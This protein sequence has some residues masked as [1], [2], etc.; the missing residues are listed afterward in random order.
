MLT[1]WA[2]SRTTCSWRAKRRAR[3]D[4]R[5][6]MELAGSLTMSLSSV[7]HYP[8]SYNS[9]IGGR[10]IFAT[11]IKVRMSQ[12]CMIEHTRGSNAIDRFPT[13]D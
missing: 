7:T 4:K 5:I 9:A 12:I 3:R 11:N 1:A 2:C 10:A 8:S 6:C 13:S